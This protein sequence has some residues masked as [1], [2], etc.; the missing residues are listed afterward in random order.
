MRIPSGRLLRTAIG[1]VLLS[2]CM[3]ATGCGSPFGTVKGKIT[4]KGQPLNRAAISFL[5]EDGRVAAAESSADG[6]YLLPQAPVGNCRLSIVCTAET[7][8]QVT[9]AMED[10]KRKGQKNPMVAMPVFKSL[11]PDRFGNPDTSGLTYKVVSGESNCNIDL[12]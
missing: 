2:V 7:G 10:I 4:Y 1:T 5:C 3:A 8:E 12:E 9:Q 6:S 11:I